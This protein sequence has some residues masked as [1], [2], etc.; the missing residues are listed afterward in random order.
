MESILLKTIDIIS[1]VRGT[2]L[3]AIVIKLISHPEFKLEL[4]KIEQNY[5]LCRLIIEAFSLMDHPHELGIEQRMMFA[6]FR[7]GGIAKPHV[8]KILHI[9][10][11]IELDGKEGFSK[12]SLECPFSFDFQNLK[13]YYSH[14]KER[15][16]PIENYWRIMEISLW[17]CPLSDEK[18]A[19]Y[20]MLAPLAV[21]FG[22]FWVGVSNRVLGKLLPPYHAV[23][24]FKLIHN[25]E[26]GQIVRWMAYDCGDRGIGMELHRAT[27]N[28]LPPIEDLLGTNASRV[29]CVRRFTNISTPWGLR[30]TLY[31]FLHYG[32]RNS[33][34]IN[35]KWHLDKHEDD[36]I[37]GVTSFCATNCW[38]F[39]N[40][41]LGLFT[42]FELTPRSLSCAM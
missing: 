7:G 19:Q 6:A 13:F 40:G 31:D 15:R 3:E 1:R 22:P 27:A 29:K 16:F 34:P 21:F 28:G 32:S 26:Y 10:R 39:V 38:G 8:E 36:V 9:Y 35:L 42:D 23:L 20:M 33:A 24:I 25:T 17:V 41:A 11:S 4:E 30:L 2:K 12:R 5:E 14:D 18:R 37:Q